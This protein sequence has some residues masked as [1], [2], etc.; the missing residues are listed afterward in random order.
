MPEGFSI[1]ISSDY[2]ELWRYNISLTGEVA[3]ADGRRTEYIGRASDVA[4]VGSSL[5][6]AP[7]CYDPD[8]RMSFTTAA[9]ERLTL[10]IYVIPHTLP[11]QRIVDQ[12]RP[13]TLHV[14]IGRSGETLYDRR[15][16]INQWSGDNIEIKLG[17]ECP[18]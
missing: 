14:R 9:G 4:P 13:F 5:K 11:K 3:D 10:Y 1:E 18:E 6:A 7:A 17:A 16:S 15:L 2:A 12:A 8:R